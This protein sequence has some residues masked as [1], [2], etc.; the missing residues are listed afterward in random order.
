MRPESGAQDVFPSARRR[1]PR[2]WRYDS[3]LAPELAWDEDEARGE[4]ERLIEE[5][6][7]GDDLDQAKQ[8]AEKLK[9]LSRHF[10]NWAG[11]AERG[12]FAVP[13]LPLFVHE[14]LST[15]AVLETLKR[16]HRKRGQTLELFG[17]SDKSI[18]E[19]IRGAYEHVNG[20]QNRL[21]LGD[22]LQVMN[23]LLEY[24]GLGG[25]VQMVY[26][27]PP[28]G[29]K[30]GGN[31]Q[32]FVRKRDV[33]DGDDDSLSREPEMVRA[34]RD[35][36]ELG[37]HSWLTYMRDR[38]LLAREM[39]TDSGSCFVQISDENVHLVRCV[40]DE[41]FGR[42]NFVSEIYFATTSGFA[43]EKISRVGD[44]LVWYAKDS[45]RMKYRSLF[46]AKNN[47]ERGDNTYRYLELQSGSRRSM[48]KAEREGMVSL[49]DDSRVF[50]CGDTQSQG[51]SSQDC[52]FE[53]EGQIFRPQPNN[54]WK[55]HYLRGMEAL[56]KSNR[57]VIVGNQLWY[58]RYADDY[59]VR[60]ITNSWM[61]TGLSFA[62]D[63]KYVVQTAEKVIQ[64][65]MLMT[66]DPGDL[67]LDPTC[68]SGTTAY[69]AE[70][71]GRRWITTD[72]SR[73]PLA[74]VRQRL[75]TATYP[76]YQLKD[77]QRGPAGGFVY[78]RKQNKKGEEVGGI[79]PHITLK[80]IANNEPPAEEVLVDKPET[81]SSVI[82]IT[83]PFCVEAVLPTPLSPEAE[84]PQVKEPV[85][86]PDNEDNHIERMIEVLRLSPVLRLQGNQEFRLDKVRPPAK[87][88]SLHAEAE[89]V[90]PGTDDGEAVAIVFGPAN[91]PVSERAVIEAGKEA[92]AKNYQMLLVI[93]FAIEPEARETVQHGEATLGLPAVYV[94]A[95]TDLV[96]SDLL[97]NTRSSQIFAVVGLP[98]VK[99]EKAP[100]KAEDGGDLWQVT[101]RGLDVFDPA[102]M[103]HNALQGDDVPCWMLDTDY[104]GQS[105]RA[106]QVF[107][108]RTS[109]WDK[110]RHAVQADFDESVWERLRGAVSAPFAAGDQIAVKVIDDRGNELMVVKKTGDP[111]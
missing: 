52:P 63:K 49:P 104:D 5:I 82:R 79:V 102:T 67:V 50:A 38:L 94:Q 19:K 73:V 3:S 51:A 41:V 56:K 103:E 70:Q 22:S 109:A 45:K 95:S 39:L 58:I 8:A 31:F 74:L 85:P 9:N 13:T 1:P 65:C 17:E 53:F 29:V 60:K 98:D 96:M 33:K 12:G 107:F 28:Y 32:P 80:S 111:K 72:V 37:I 84:L 18:G 89:H 10:L 24:E 15:E 81:E 4:G 36:W 99:L 61:D 54:H 43:T 88:L 7:A 42:E 62:M 23:S 87:S 55:A 101:L 21:I 108:P 106:G 30:F 16:R 92:H 11:K 48:T 93:A 97:K 91:G 75:L 14:R 83:G 59:P 64:R 40:M 34:Y 47:T 86:P 71:W 2:T 110:I 20:W 66:T 44:Y 57:L 26:M 6:I 69:V 25:Q 78:Q 35:T 100:E 68:G 46:V 27:D 77:E 76:Y 105:F 90:A